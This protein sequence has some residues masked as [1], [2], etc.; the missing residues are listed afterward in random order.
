MNLTTIFRHQAAARL[1][2]ALFLGASA[3]CGARAAA[4]AAPSDSTLFIIPSP[5]EI[6]PEAKLSGESNLG[7]F[8]WGAEIGSSVDLTGNDMTSLDI[9]GQFGYKG[10]GTR[11]AGIGA[12]INSMMNNS[13]RCYPVY[14][15]FRTSF[16]RQPRLCF[17]DLRL[18][19]S[20]NNIL[21]FKSQTGFY[22]SIGAGITLAKGKKFSSHI[23]V[24]YTFLPIRPF[25]VISQTEVEG[26]PGEEFEDTPPQTETTVS[27]VSFPDLHFATIRIGCSF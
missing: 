23:I 16:A 7:H 11:L 5:S 26:R 14:A 10:P 12:G 2:A 18:G 4:P 1:A 19:V 3:L 25:N 13:S 8:T 17:M 22:G 9:H 21:D 27:K 20:F 15:I 24:A 6:A